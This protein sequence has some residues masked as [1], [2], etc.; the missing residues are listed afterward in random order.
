MTNKRITITEL[1]SG[2][3]ETEIKPCTMTELA[4]FYHMDRRTLNRQLKHMKTEIGKRHGYYFTIE[5]V[6]KILDELGI[7]RKIEFESTE[8][9]ES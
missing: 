8:I 5:Q 7:P 3:F 9:R 6:R 1:G 2:K 4:K